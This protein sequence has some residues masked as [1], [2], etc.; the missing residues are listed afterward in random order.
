MR[1]WR[2]VC[3]CCL[4]VV[5]WLPLNALGAFYF[6]RD[7]VE[8]EV[9]LDNA[10]DT[11]NKTITVTFLSSCQLSS[12]GWAYYQDY[13]M[14]VSNRSMGDGEWGGR[15]DL[16]QSGGE[17]FLSRVVY[18]NRDIYPDRNGWSKLFELPREDARWLDAE[19]DIRLNKSGLMS[20]KPGE[21]RSFYIIGLDDE[22]TRFRDTLEVRVIRKGNTKVKISGLEDVALDQQTLTRT[23]AFCVYVSENGW[24]RLK[25]SSQAGAAASRFQLTNR[26][27]VFVDYQLDFRRWGGINWQ[28]MVPDTFYNGYGYWLEDCGG[29]SNASFRVSVPVPPRQS[30]IYQDT[31]T[32]TVEPL[33]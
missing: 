31:V 21:S 27:G 13:R 17:D 16:D 32:V 11:I 4:I 12:C 24:Y 7:L 30:G 20:L 26:A 15:P 14:G 29:N 2:S 8:I 33:Y 1:Q 19:F 25:A 10:S 3:L 28:P 5:C 22:S 23:M 9:D 6:D 18:R